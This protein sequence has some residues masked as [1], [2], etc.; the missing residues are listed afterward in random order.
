MYF[1]VLSSCNVVLWVSIDLTMWCTACWS[2]R[3]PRACHKWRS[4]TRIQKNYTARFMIFAHIPHSKLQ[5]RVRLNYNYLITPTWRTFSLF[6]LTTKYHT[7][8]LK[9][10]MKTRIA[11]DVKYFLS[12][13]MFHIMKN[14]CTITFLFFSLI[15]FFVRSLYH[16]MNLRFPVSS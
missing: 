1:A 8:I 5:S 11:V 6:C 3:T 14:F 12:V 9:S 13:F 15:F 10:T 4:I 2:P 16:T 7:E